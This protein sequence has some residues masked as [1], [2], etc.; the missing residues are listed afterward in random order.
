M[1]NNSTGKFGIHVW[2]W[3]TLIFFISELV[4]YFVFKFTAAADSNYIIQPGSGREVVF[5]IILGCLII[6]Y[7][8]TLVYRHSKL[9]VKKIP[10]ITKA[11][12]ILLTVLFVIGNI[13]QLILFFNN[14]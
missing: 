12:V 7:L 4:L 8:W 14:Q 6:T 11:G 2:G 13:C 3:A 5:E 1:K 10:V 9:S